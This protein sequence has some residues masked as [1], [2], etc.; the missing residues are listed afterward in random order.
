[1]SAMLCLVWKQHKVRAATLDTTVPVMSSAAATKVLRSKAFLRTVAM[2]GTTPVRKH[3]VRMLQNAE[4]GLV[5]TP[6]RIVA[7]TVLV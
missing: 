3:L 2:R 4:R 5:S 1:M 6:A 7:M